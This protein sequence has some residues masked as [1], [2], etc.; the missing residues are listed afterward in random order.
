MMLLIVPIIAWFV[1]VMYCAFSLTLLWS[2]FIVPFGITDITF[3]WSVGLLCV[4]SLIKG[5]PSPNKEGELWS[6]VVKDFALAS[7]ALAVGFIAHQFM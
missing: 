6:F 4:I 2:W 1:A 7:L 5:V 3:P